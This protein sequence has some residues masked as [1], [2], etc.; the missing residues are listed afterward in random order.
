MVAVAGA[1]R[2]R[3]ESKFIPE[4]NTGC[5]IWLAQT[6]KHGYGRF[7]IDGAKTTAQRASWL[8]YRGTIP[9]GLEIDHKCKLRCCVNPD[10]LQPL[11]KPANLAQRAFAKKDSCPKGHPYSGDNLS[12]TKN[13]NGKVARRC[14]I[15]TRERNRV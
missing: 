6:D 1:V 8:I 14:R 13:G 10:H 7:F 11:S 9:D 3:F 5:W 4:P 12:I 2:P 15:C